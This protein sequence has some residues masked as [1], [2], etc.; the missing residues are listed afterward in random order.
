M[1]GKAGRRTGKAASNRSTLRRYIAARH[2]QR[3]RLR[4]IRL[5]YQGVTEGRH[6]NFSM[7]LVRSARDYRARR[8]PGKGAVNLPTQ[9]SA[10]GRL[11]VRFDEGAGLIS[12][13]LLAMSGDPTERYLAERTVQPPAEL[14][15]G[16]RDIP[17]HWPSATLLA[18]GPGSDESCAF[19]E[20]DCR[21]S[22]RG[23]RIGP[24]LDVD[25][26]R[27][28]RRKLRL[29]IE[30]NFG[31]PKPRC[32]PHQIE[33]LSGSRAGGPFHGRPQR[34]EAAGGWR[35]TLWPLTERTRLAPAAFDPR[36]PGSLRSPS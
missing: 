4:L 15:P 11:V 24:G 1:G 14:R 9:P 30:G 13:T 22:F 7:I 33:R 6:V 27:L 32:R 36:P 31:A 26:R 29:R 12:S 2:R 8:V 5:R 23:R 3:E 17:E 25:D 10:S 19:I 28:A 16:S 20:P 35:Q 18:H 34:S 21:S